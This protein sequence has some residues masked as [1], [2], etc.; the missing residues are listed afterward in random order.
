MGVM[1][2]T[3][4][5]WRWWRR[6]QHTHNESAEYTMLIPHFL[7]LICLLGLLLE[8]GLVHGRPL[9]SLVGEGGSWSLGHLFG[10]WGLC[11][12]SLSVCRSYTSGETKDEGREWVKVREKGTWRWQGLRVVGARA[13]GEMRVSWV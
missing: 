10:L 7:V 2:Q 9:F 13:S 11:L 12:L 6:G 5:V 1:V 8:F 3:G 4:V